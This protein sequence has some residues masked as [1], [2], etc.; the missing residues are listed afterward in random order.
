[1]DMSGEWWLTIVEKEDG[2]IHLMPHSRLE[3]IREQANL[4]GLIAKPEPDENG[5]VPTEEVSDSAGNGEIVDDNGTMYLKV[6]D[7]TTITLGDGSKIYASSLDMDSVYDMYQ[8]AGYIVDR[9]KGAYFEGRYSVD[10]NGD[11][12]H[13]ISGVWKDLVT[14]ET[15]GFEDERLTE[16]WYT[17]DPG[18]DSYECYFGRAKPEYV[19][20]GTFPTGYLADKAF[21]IVDGKKADCM[22]DTS[23]SVFWG[24]IQEEI[25]YEVKEIYGELYVISP[26]L[27]EYAKGRTVSIDGIDGICYKLIPEGEKKDMYLCMEY[28]SQLPVN[29]TYKLKYDR[30]NVVD[31]YSLNKYST[32][33]QARTVWLQGQ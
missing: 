10:D 9:E 18:S 20:N 28:Y 19:S 26:N 21:I 1:M 5:E 16:Y 27:E 30:F 4:F 14:N 2:S 23:G 31:M 6:N 13:L 12:T 22:Y 33:P 24:L 29:G 15:V 11:V 25:D 7:T 3:T 32:D 8:G 17:Y